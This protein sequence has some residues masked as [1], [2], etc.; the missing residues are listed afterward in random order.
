MQQNR[1]ICKKNIRNRICHLKL[2][3]HV[4][5]GI[6]LAYRLN[7]ISIF[8]FYNNVEIDSIFDIVCIQDLNKKAVCII[9][10]HLD[11]EPIFF[12]RSRLRCTSN[13]RKTRIK[14]QIAYF[15]ILYATARPRWSFFATILNALFFFRG[16]DA[17][18]RLLTKSQMPKVVQEEVCSF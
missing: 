10:L 14:I 18:L 3:K 9:F 4:V 8:P 7:R 11:R 16:A 2:N 15:R 17:R 12:R 6:T 5:N 13:H 1:K